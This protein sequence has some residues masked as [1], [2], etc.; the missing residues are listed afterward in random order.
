MKLM[1]GVTLALALALLAPASGAQAE[2][3][4]PTLSMPPTAAPSD[5]YIFAGGGTPFS[6]GIFFPGTTFCADGDCETQG[7]P[8][9]VAKGN[10]VTFVNLDAATV[11]NS[12][13]IMSRDKKKAKGK[14]KSRKPLFAS[15]PVDGPGSVTMK[16]SHLEPGVYLYICTTHFGMDGALEVYEP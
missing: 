8:A 2:L 5:G 7:P 11:A 6:N 10:D 14:K 4:G 9:R 15:E 16:T 3:P 12:H 1:R 13:Q